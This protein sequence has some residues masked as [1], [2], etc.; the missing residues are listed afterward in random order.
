MS[1]SV[2]KHQ[3]LLIVL[4]SLCYA[5]LYRKRHGVFPVNLYGIHNIIK[6]DKSTSTGK[7]TNMIKTTILSNAELNT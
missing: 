6:G 3:T 7:T 1:L 2:Q 5:F 4:N